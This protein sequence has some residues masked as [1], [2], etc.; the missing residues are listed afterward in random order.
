MEK[1]RRLIARI[2]VIGIIASMVISTIIWAVQL[3]V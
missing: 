2:V 3:S 1:K